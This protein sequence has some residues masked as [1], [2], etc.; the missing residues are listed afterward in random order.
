[1]TSK[2]LSRRDLVAAK[3]KQSPHAKAEAGKALQR[4]IEGKL[5]RRWYVDLTLKRA[6]SEDKTSDPPASL[7]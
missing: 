5:D 1:M 4:L 2:Y 7:A 6:T 3:V